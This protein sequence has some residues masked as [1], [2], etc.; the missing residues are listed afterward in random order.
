[1][2]D[3]WASDDASERAYV[4]DNLARLS[5]D[6]ADAGDLPPGQVI[7]GV[8]D[9]LATRTK[10]GA[11]VARVTCMDGVDRLVA[12][13]SSFKPST[14]DEPGDAEEYLVWEGISGA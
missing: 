14:R 5:K 6:D 7:T 13:G 3:V 11:L 8:L 2:A 1:M 10:K 9:V 4:R 12:Y